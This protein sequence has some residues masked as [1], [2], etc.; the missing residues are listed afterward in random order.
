MQIQPHNTTWKW[1]EDNIKSTVMKCFWCHNNVLVHT[2]GNQRHQFATIYFQ[3]ALAFYNCVEDGRITNYCLHHYSTKGKT[4][5]SYS[6]HVYQLVL[7]VLYQPEVLE[8]VVGCVPSPPLFYAF[9]YFNGSVTFL[10][11]FLC[12]FSLW[13]VFQLL[14]PNVKSMNSN[15]YHPQKCQALTWP[16]ILM[17]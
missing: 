8:F 13:F 9:R 4:R 11:F 10:I 7:F 2:T 17:T 12:N 5:H 6:M 14:Q 3:Y 15:Y 16:A 1:R